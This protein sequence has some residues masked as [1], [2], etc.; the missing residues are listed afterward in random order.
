MSS[1]SAVFYNPAAVSDLEGTEVKAGSSIVFPRISFESEVTRSKTTIRPGPVFPSYLFATREFSNAWST[2][3]GIYSEIGNKVEYPQDW[4]G[5]FFLTSAKL[6]QINLSPILA[7]RMSENVSIGAGPVLTY[8]TTKQSNQIPLNPFFLPGEGSLNIDADG[9]GIGG[10]VGIK[11]TF[12]FSIIGVVYRSP[13]SIK[14]KGDARFSVPQPLSPLFP[15]GDVE[16]AQKFPQM[17]VIGFG[18]Q[19]IPRLLIEADIQWTNWNNFN[20]QVLG[21]QNKSPAIQD[22]TIRF[23]WK[24][25]WTVRVGGHYD[26]N[27][28]VTARL[29]YTFDPS[30]VPDS[31]LSPLVPEM[32]KHIISSGV[33]FRKGLLGVDVFYAV[34]IGESRNVNN[35]LI[36]FPV[37]RGRYSGLA[38]GGGASITYLF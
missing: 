33:G 15:N 8:A 36:G 10:I 19:P 18:H 38:H 26:I 6:T 24:D 37:H 29:G 27:D 12:S 7:Y 32:D 22:T 14:L 3:V 23:D 35:S 13:M 25:T 34:A 11:M 17:V 9:Y 5:R 16:T 21:F 20:E 1:P 30:A 28:Q 31:T 4:E 2:G